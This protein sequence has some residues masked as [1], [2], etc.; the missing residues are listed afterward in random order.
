VET[1]LFNSESP[2]HLKFNFDNNKYLPYRIN[3]IIGKNGTGKTRLLAHLANGISGLKENRYIRFPNGK[4]TFP[5]L[6][7][8]S[9]SAFGKF[10]KPL[11]T[12][13]LDYRFLGLK[14]KSNNF[15][16]EEKLRSKLTIALEEV[17]ARGKVN[18]WEK[19]INELFEDRADEV[20]EAAKINFGDLKISSGQN[21]LLYIITELIAYTKKN[22]LIMFDEP[23][24]YL[25]PNAVTKLVNILYEILSENQSYAIVA[26]HSPII[27]QSIPAKYMQ[28]LENIEGSALIKKLNVGTF[29]ENLS[30]ITMKFLVFWI[31]QLNIKNCC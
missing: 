2:L 10:E 4:P 29:G 12:R 24:L 21:F 25:H 26:T 17:R 1:S 13:F 18:V 15:L 19:F 27:V 23:E 7:S 9:Y 28:V 5:N 6:I 8:V 31:L 22:T 20:L 30:T 3:A 11:S 14:D 16:D